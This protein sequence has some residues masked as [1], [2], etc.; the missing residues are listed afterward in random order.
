M[1]YR[2]TNIIDMTPSGEFLPR[3]PRLS[4]PARI[5]IGAA[6]VAFVAVMV[7]AAALFLWLAAVMLPIAI[8][9]GAIAYVAFKLQLWRPRHG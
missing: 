6:V 5:G 2:A 7:S 3:G 9:A 4:W 8:V 1:V